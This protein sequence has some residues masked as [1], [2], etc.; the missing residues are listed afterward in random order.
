M[1]YRAAL[2]V[3]YGV[4]GFVIVY[5]ALARNIA[6]I[7]KISMVSAKIPANRFAQMIEKKVKGTRSK[8]EKGA[9]DLHK[10]I[11]QSKEKLQELGMEKEDLK[12]EKMDSK[13]AKESARLSQINS[14][15]KD[16][17]EKRKRDFGL[18]KESKKQRI[19]RT[20]K[21]YRKSTK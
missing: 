12:F 4:W 11:E 9:E 7:S 10:T 5:L 3:A 13:L 20:K 16:L 15:L 1:Q 21:R 19:K 2:F 14:K 6:R 8:L 17:M 18:E